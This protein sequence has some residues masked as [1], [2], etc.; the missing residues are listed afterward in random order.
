MVRIDK[1]IEYAL[2]ILKH[3]KYNLDKLTKVR[4]I[5]DKYLLSF[6]M[7]AKVMRSLNIN[8]IIS[9]RPGNKGGS[10]L[11]NIDINLLELSKA[12]NGSNKFA[13]CIEKSCNSKCSIRSSILSL[14]LYL[15]KF[16]SSIKI[17]EIL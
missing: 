8:K 6:D 5:S 10:K 16:I 9:S 12:I 15:R 13:K 1:K 2:I 11:N 14:D 17:E 3:M 4:D 7:V